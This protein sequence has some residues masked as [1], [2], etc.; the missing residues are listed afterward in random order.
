MPS[1]GPQ[2]VVVISADMG[3]GHNATARALAE[4]AHQCWPG[5]E[6]SWLNTLD[7]MGPGVGPLFRSIYVANV[8][9]TPWLYE[10]FYASLWRHPWFARASKA[11]VGA[12]SGRPLAR[13][14]T[15]LRPDVVL[16]TYPLGSAGLAWLRKRGR[17]PQPAGAWVSDFSPHP[18]WVYAELDATFV[19]HDLAVPVAEAAETGARLAVCPAPVVRAFPEAAASHAGSPVRRGLGVPDGALL[20]LVSCGAYGFGTVRQA[21]AAVLDAGGEVH[22][23]AVTGTN[24]T[25]RGELEDGFRDDARAHILGWVDDMPALLAASD[26]VVSNAG[27]ATAL[28]ALAAGRRVVMFQPIAAHGRANA[29][30]MAQAGVAE[31]CDTP[32]ELTAATRRLL[33]RPREDRRA[34]PVDGL[35]T[36]QAL[37]LLLA[38]PVR[39]TESARRS[40]KR[41]PPAEGS[42]WPCA[43]VP[44]AQRLPA[45]DAVFLDIDTAAVPQQIGTVVLLEP[46]AAGPLSI[47]AAR[48]LAEAIP[49]VQGRLSRGRLWRSPTWRPIGR[50][51]GPIAS[52]AD[53]D[54]HD[55]SAL[56]RAV[57]E[58]FSHRLDLAGPPARIRLLD[59]LPDGRQAL[60]VQAHHALCDGVVLIRALV[61][62]AN[63][64]P[65]DPSAGLA[66]V[67]A[68]P[69]RQAGPPPGRARGGW[70]HRRRA[71]LLLLDGVW[72]LARAGRA[73][74]TVLAA[75]VASASRHHVLVPLPAEAVRRAARAHGTSTGELLIALLMDA[76]GAAVPGACDGTGT[77]RV[78]VPRT[79]RGRGETATTTSLDGGNR[80]GAT[81]VDLPVGRLP[82]A[83]RI[84]AVGAVMRRQAHGDQPQ[85]ARAVLGLVGSLPPVLRRPL[86]RAMYRS[87]WFSAVA[88][89]LP[90]LVRD[91]HIAGSTVTDAFPVLPLAP[92]TQLAFGAIPRRDVV[93]V[94][95]TLGPVLGPYGDALAGALSDSLQRACP[96]D[97]P[98]AEPEPLP[99]RTP[100][101]A[102]VGDD[103]GGGPTHTDGQE[104]DGLRARPA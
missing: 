15:E 49:R 33:E 37:E 71:G 12:W 8:E 25:L 90:G 102:L 79:L 21:V 40:A 76:V 6:V 3:E 53:L 47:Q 11:F 19:M 100:V 62:R 93:D 32:A 51:A 70:G 95:L 92:G 64:L 34:A 81:P 50:G 63:A 56:G 9:T 88:T 87:T 36:A 43:E 1:D 67:P 48:R 89:V 35:S 60:L 68:A 65:A 96:A 2:R 22:V 57:D 30:L 82:L 14:L 97:A 86:N 61:E 44:V 58:F 54:L 41:R 77:L 45:A 16:S 99:L 98:A 28:E 59:G 69:S 85:A 104:T 38:G 72:S 74:R 46:G 26:T 42:T 80:T 24:A 23:A 4:A 10:F 52:T 31:V 17:L 94:C 73:P 7:L 75:R 101:H 103:G 27:G 84:E 66:D 78:L 39:S 18:F 20:V 55:P 91:V 29:E 5:C 13:R 83:E